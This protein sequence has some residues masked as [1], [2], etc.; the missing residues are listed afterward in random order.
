MEL[1]SAAALGLSGATGGMSL[2]LMALLSLG[3]SGLMSLFSGESPR[4][5]GFE[6]M[7]KMVK[8]NMAVL[9]STPYTKAELEGIVEGMKTKL[10]GAASV[11]AGA[12]GNKIAE[13]LGAAGTPQGQPSGSMYVSEVAPTIAQ[14]QFLSTEAD[15]FGVEAFSKMDANSKQMLLQALGLMGGGAQG[16]PDMTSGEKSMATLL[17]SF[18]LFTK[19]FGNLMK[20]VKDYNYQPVT[21]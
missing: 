12:A 18:D 21:P 9:K 7:L 3:G 5:K 13:S 4:D 8:E 20:G 17:Q 6:E 2:P 11:G 14:G 10:T 1:A 16:L 15:K 19:G